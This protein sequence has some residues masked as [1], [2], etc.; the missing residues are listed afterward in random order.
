[1]A[2]RKNDF[3][4]KTK[5][6]VAGRVGYRCSIPSCGRVT[7]GPNSLPRRVAN[8]GRAAHIFS[9]A[10]RGPRGHGGLTA[11]QLRSE[12]NAIWLC[13]EHADLVD[14]NRGESYPPALLL[15]YKHL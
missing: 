14:K 15:S 12:S 1:M 8:T 6:V 10:E 7:I 11:E 13:A 3:S 4:A 5:R 2:K 9:A